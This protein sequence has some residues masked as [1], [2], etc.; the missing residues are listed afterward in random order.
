MG[1]EPCPHCGGSGRIYEPVSGW[2]T[3]WVDCPHC[4][5]TKDEEQS[6]E[7]QGWLGWLWRFFLG[8]TR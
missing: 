1:A 7:P 8:R 6:A 4:R 5:T 3:D 2:Q